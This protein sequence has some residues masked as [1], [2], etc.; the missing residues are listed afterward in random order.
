MCWKTRREKLRWL[1]SA[2]TIRARQEHE[3]LDHRKSICEHSWICGPMCLFL[4]IDSCQTKGTETPPSCVGPLRPQDECESS[5]ASKGI[6]EQ[7]K[8]NRKESHTKQQDSPQP[9]CECTQSGRPQ[10]AVKNKNSEQHEQC[11][12]QNNLVK[13]Q[14][15]PYVQFITQDELQAK[16]EKI[17][18]R[19]LKVKE[20]SPYYTEIECSK[21]AAPNPPTQRRSDVITSQP[22]PKAKKETAVTLICTY[23]GAKFTSQTNHTGACPE[24]PSQAAALL[25][26]LTCHSCVEA[27][28][29]HCAADAD[30]EYGDPYSCD[31]NDEMCKTRWAYICCLGMCMPCVFCEFPLR[32]CLKV[33]AQLHIC[34]ARHTD[35]F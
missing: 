21:N 15:G 6:L 3:T 32:A 24:G 9:D 34:G 4:Q 23:C 16:K 12:E 7:E 5:A 17:Q 28:T 29:Y 19:S 20:Q 13:G 18:P 2:Q 11:E 1:I 27:V 26:K 10:P 31:R 22:H 14:D 30:G 33:C 25:K 8:T 35:K